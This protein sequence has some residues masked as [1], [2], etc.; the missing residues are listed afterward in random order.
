VN[1]YY[2]MYIFRVGHGLAGIFN[3]N[4]IQV[5]V[6]QKRANPLLQS[7]DTMISEIAANVLFSFVSSYL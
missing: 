4:Q 1:I 2:V 6:S 7:R 5:E 3:H